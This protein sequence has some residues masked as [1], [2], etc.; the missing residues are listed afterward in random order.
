MNGRQEFASLTVRTGEPQSCPRPFSLWTASST[1]MD[2][3]MRSPSLHRGSE[4]PLVFSSFIEA[5]APAERPSEWELESGSVGPNLRLVLGPSC[6]SGSC[7]TSG[8]VASKGEAPTFAARVQLSTKVSTFSTDPDVKICVLDHFLMS[9][10][11]L[12][13]AKCRSSSVSGPLCPL[14]LQKRIANLHVLHSASYS[15]YV[16]IL[17]TYRSF[18]KDGEVVVKIMKGSIFALC[19]CVNG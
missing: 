3:C 7:A 2:R 1:S 18:A 14:Q 5:A 16:F 10:S 6:N 13:H 17:G 15:F 19:D 4:G 11:S 8:P 12:L 9:H